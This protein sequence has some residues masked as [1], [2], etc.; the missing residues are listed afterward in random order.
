MLEKKLQNEEEEEEGSNEVKINIE[1][2]PSLSSSFALFHVK[3]I[4]S[5]NTMTKLILLAGCKLKIS[6][7]ASFPLFKDMTF[8]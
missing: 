6:F 2:I 8:S 5:M 4:K 1:F 7:S 3:T